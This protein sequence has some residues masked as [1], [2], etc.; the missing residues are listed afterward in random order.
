VSTA[1]ADV[2]TLG[3][4]LTARAA[5]LGGATFVRQDDRAL[6]YREA[7]MSANQAAHGLAS[8]GI[9]AGD[10]VCVLL[11]NSLEFLLVWFGLAKLGAIEVPLNTAYKGWQLANLIVES[12][13]AVL[14]TERRFLRQVRA[15]QTG[16]RTIV[17]V[18]GATG[19]DPYTV[20]WAELVRDR[21]A[22]PP[23]VVVAPEDPVAIMHTSGTTSASKGVVLCH[24]HETHVADVIG[25]HCELGREDVFYCYLPL[26]HNAAQAM[27]T[28][29]VLRF[30]AS[31]VLAERF[32]A[33]RFWPDVSRYGC[34]LFFCMGPVVD[35]LLATEA[36]AP[37]RHGHPLRLGWGI[38]YSA[39]TARRFHDRF[40]V[41]LVGGYGAT[42]VGMVTLHPREDPRLDT[43][44][45]PLR[46]CEVRVVDADDEPVPVGAVGEIVVRPNRPYITTLGYHR[47]PEETAAF[48]RNGWLHTGDAG[49]F[50]ADGYLSFV[51][52]IK[53]VIRRR[54]ENVSSFEVEMVALTYPGV[55][56]CAA[57]AT[58][59]DEGAYGDEIYLAVVL[60]DGADLDPAAL[61]A[62]CAEKLAYFAVPRYIERWDSL[63]KTPTGKIRK[64]EIRGHGRGESTWD[65][66]SRGGE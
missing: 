45:R 32:S 60:E 27:V 9:A 15:E 43:A 28:W 46:H 55:V 56:E 17:L 51:D 6:T 21:P 16:L 58:P 50:D 14:V 62:Y 23:D 25:G 40:G 19:A 24:E 41:P 52:R 66:Q 4:L 35:F 22:T 42:E 64:T 39:E 31:L 1:L 53:D 54:G 47:R 2:R 49:R 29:S 59:A 34:T 38:G 63:P 18:D 8:L 44:G 13:A 5:E 37:P 36:Q 7:E 20:D 3:D 48:M 61:A 11:D 30:G 10:T 65:R 33:S 57:V 26:F 12:G